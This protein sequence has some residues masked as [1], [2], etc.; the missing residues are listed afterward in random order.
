M[1]CEALRIKP[2][3]FEVVETGGH[4]YQAVIPARR[5]IPDGLQLTVSQVLAELG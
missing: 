5:E 4:F 1:V 2:P 3:E